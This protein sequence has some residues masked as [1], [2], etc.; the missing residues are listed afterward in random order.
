M[1]FT[2]ARWIGAAMLLAATGRA[3]TGS[4]AKPDEPTRQ[5]VEAWLEARALPADVSAEP[6]PE[7]PPLPPRDHGFVVEGAVGALG[8]IGDMRFI[9]PMSPLFHLKIG[10]EPVRWLMLFALGDVAFGSTSL[11]N[12]PPGPRSYYLWGIGAGVR[13]T[14]E[15]T[16]WLGLFV[17]AEIGAARVSE[18]VLATYGFADADSVS[19]YF[20]A[21]LGLE[22][23]QVS[24]HL[25]LVTQGGIRNYGEMLDRQ[26][27]GGTPLA[28]LAS[29]GISYTF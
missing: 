29:A 23:Y 19:P 5:E 9:S 10:W 20:G 3:E 27:S 14:W 13:A 6:A 8:H 2:T 21:G 7:A 22:W 4:P 17:Q 28:W 18:D 1:R 25:A 24:P 11:A 26:L 15:P 12:P 16:D